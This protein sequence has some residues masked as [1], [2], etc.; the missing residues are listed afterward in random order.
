MS[1]TAQILH[2]NNIVQSSLTPISSQ[3]LVCIGGGGGG[4]G[5]DG[6]RFKAFK[7][8]G[9]L[10]KIISVVHH[11]LSSLV[12][13]YSRQALNPESSDLDVALELQL[14][15]YNDKYVNPESREKNNKILLENMG[16]THK[17]KL[18]KKRYPDLK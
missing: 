16:P 4:G 11:F 6:G 14:E 5:G 7:A 3:A 18:I 17:V 8:L 13:V 9:T 15:G 2:P 10:F 12:V 1:D